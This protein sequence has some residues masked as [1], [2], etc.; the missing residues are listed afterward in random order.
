MDLGKLSLFKL[1]GSRMGYLAER[2]KVLS[3]NIAN[4][5]TPQYRPSDLKPMDFQ[6][7]LGGDQRVKMAVTNKVHLAGT[8]QAPNFAAEKAA[9]GKSYETAPNGNAVV[10]EEQMMKVAEVQSNYQLAANLY[11]KNMSM[12]RT[13]IGRT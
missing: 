11:Q 7:V 4:A 12:L 1:V 3:Q 10:L 6:K 9:F 13:A 8:N 2:Q 5:D